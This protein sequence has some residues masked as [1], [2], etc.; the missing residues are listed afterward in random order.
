MTFMLQD[1]TYN[2]VKN[3]AKVFLVMNSD[4]STPDSFSPKRTKAVMM[5]IMAKTILVHK[6]HF[7][8]ALTPIM[9][10]ALAK[11]ASP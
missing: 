8:L 10:K 6:Q 1:T 11:V 7:V 4:S 5:E 9:L 3:T 2:C